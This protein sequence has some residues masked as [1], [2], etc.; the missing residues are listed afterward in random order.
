V[1]AAE[2]GPSAVTQLQLGAP[3]AQALVAAYRPVRLTRPSAFRLAS[4][5]VWA[6][7]ARMWSR[8]IC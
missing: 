1:Q 8:F 5:P 3:N 4:G 7:W 2:T 6:A